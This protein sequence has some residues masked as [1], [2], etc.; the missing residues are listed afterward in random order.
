MQKI[1]QRI[2]SWMQ[3]NAPSALNTLQPGASDTQIQTLEKLFSKELPEDVKLSYKIHNGQ[4]PNSYGLID[5]SEFLSLERIQEEWQIWQELLDSDTFAGLWSYPQ[6]GVRQ[7]W[8]NP[9]WIPLTYDGGSNHYCLDL[10]PGKGGNLG[11][12]ITM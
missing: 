6:P 11:Q 4:L 3:E 2:E 9:L 5:G 7:D 12:I 8:W 1:W 10:D